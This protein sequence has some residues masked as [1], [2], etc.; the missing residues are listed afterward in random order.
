MKD[1]YFGDVNDFLKYGILRELSKS[2]AHLHV[3]WM[4]TPSDGGAD[5]KFTDYLLEPRTWRPYDP[6][7]FDFLRSEVIDRGRRSVEAIE[8]WEGLPGSYTSTL[9]P[10]DRSGRERWTAEMIAAIQD[11]ALVFFDP[12]NGI[13]VPSCPVG[14]KRSSKYV[15]WHELAR[16]W[17]RGA[18]LLVYQHFTRA[19]RPQFL[20]RLA[21]EFR[22]RLGVERV[23]VMRTPRVAFFLVPQNEWLGAAEQHAQE[24]QARWKPRI[25]VHEVVERTRS[26]EDASV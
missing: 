9:V 12:D 6:G 5:G 8:S 16:A 24:V 15:Y 7:L 3:V 23:L 26:I 20:E 2:V 19:H 21:L 10:D 25:R 14:R 4:L 18:S 17:S 22:E 11:H 1:Q 13:E